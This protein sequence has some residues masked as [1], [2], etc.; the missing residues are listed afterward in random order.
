[1]R[2]HVTVATLYMDVVSRG[3]GWEFSVLGRA[4]EHI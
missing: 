1:M 3:G 2:M 4:T